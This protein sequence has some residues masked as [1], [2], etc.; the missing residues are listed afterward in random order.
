[1]VA[2]PVIEF[3]RHHPTLPYLQ[4]KILRQRKDFIKM[5][6]TANFP[7]ISEGFATACNQTVAP[8]SLFV[9]AI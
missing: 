5:G 9:I 7:Q 8:L 4:K 2:S 6:I 1:M 3:I